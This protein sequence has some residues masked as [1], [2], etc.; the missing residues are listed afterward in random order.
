MWNI[1][2]RLETSR[3]K[4]KRK[5]PSKGRVQLYLYYKESDLAKVTKLT[6]NFIKGFINAEKMLFLHQN[7]QTNPDKIYIYT[8]YNMQYKYTAWSLNILNHN[9]YLK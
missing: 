2:K 4:S 9:K 6:K 3:Q 1:T 8:F 7:V 5:C